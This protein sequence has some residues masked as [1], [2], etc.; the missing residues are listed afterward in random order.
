MPCIER[1]DSELAG[2]AGVPDGRLGNRI[3]L[4]QRYIRI[5]FSHFSGAPPS[6]IVVAIARQRAEPA[7]DTE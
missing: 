5:I 6:P 1:A 2:C 4:A 3:L 7:L